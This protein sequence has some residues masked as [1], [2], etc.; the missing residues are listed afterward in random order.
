M[1]SVK[2]LASVSVAALVAAIA[3][4]AWASSEDHARGRELFRL[5][6]QCHGPD[7]GGNQ[8]FLAPAIAG[9]DEWYVQAQLEKFQSGVRGTHPEDVGG[10]RMY[11]MSLSLKDEANIQAVA[12]YV[13]SLPRTD[14]QPVLQGGDPAHGAELYAI[15]TQC[16][17]P[18]GAGNETLN[19]PRLAG[20]SDWYLLSSLEKFKAGIRGG[21]PKNPTATLMRGMSMTL[22]DEQAMKDVIAHIE[23]FQD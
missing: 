17:G 7:G 15:C 14:P 5:C 22:P 20:T 9:L 12:G 1:E 19:A 18:E 21:N 23:T 4:A 8:T 11:P 13:A 6:E 10:L 3:F 16:H 2:Y